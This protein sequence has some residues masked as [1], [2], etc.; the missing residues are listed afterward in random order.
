MLAKDFADSW[1]VHKYCKP[2]AQPEDTC[3][4]NPERRTWAKHKCSVLKSE[5]FKPCHYEVDV[6]EYFKR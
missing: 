6:E 3:D 1:R 4:K 2:A 5:L